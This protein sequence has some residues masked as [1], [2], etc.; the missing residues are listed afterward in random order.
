MPLVCVYEL[1]STMQNTAL[2]VV[3]TYIDIQRFRQ[4]VAYAQDN[5]ITHK[6][7]FDRI[8]ERVEAGVGRRVDLEQASGRLALAEAN[9][10][11]ELTNL[12]DVEARYQRLVGELPPAT[13]SDVDFYKAGVETTAT[14][15]LQLAYRQNPALLSTIEKD[16]KSTRLNSS[17]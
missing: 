10:L 12:H 2:E 6:Q 17:H 16:R 14:E 9:L 15:A 4:L 7:L 1:L 3:R 8:Q 5:Y 11:T 13:V